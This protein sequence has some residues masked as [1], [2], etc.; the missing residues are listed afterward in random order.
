MTTADDEQ[1]SGTA[2]GAITI[3]AL[4]AADDLALDDLPFGVVGMDAEGVVKRYNR[5]ESRLAGLSRDNVLGESFFLTTGV[6]MNNYLVAQRFEDEAVLDVTLDY[7][8]TFRMRP[9]PVKLRLLKQL[10]G[11]FHYVLIQR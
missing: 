3:A 4:D 11:P 9:T 6:C 7:V 5:V 10:D 8:L 1:V 2:F